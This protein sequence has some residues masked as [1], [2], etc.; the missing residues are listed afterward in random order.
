MRFNLNDHFQSQK[1][2][3]LKGA[4]A[5]DRLLLLPTVYGQTVPVACRIFLSGG[6]RWLVLQHYGQ[7]PDIEATMTTS[8]NYRVQ[9]LYIDLQRSDPP[10]SALSDLVAVVT[11]SASAQSELWRLFAFGREDVRHSITE[12]LQQHGIDIHA[13]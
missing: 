5:V 8:V 12:A 1:L 7:T 3:K 11:H 6:T 2:S 13:R 4:A 10:G 9:Q